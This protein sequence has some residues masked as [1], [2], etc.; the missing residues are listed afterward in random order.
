MIDGEHF[1]ALGVLE[2]PILGA[3][4]PFTWLLWV[5]L[6]RA[7]FAIFAR[8]FD[9]PVRSHAEPLFG[10]VSN[11]V[12]FYPDT[13]GIKARLHLRD[14]LLRP[15]IELEPTSHPLA[16][17]QREGYSMKEAERLMGLLLH[18]HATAPDQRA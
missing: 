9:D 14:D 2:T 17:A 8:T 11:Q 13:L 16:V 1:F 3:P 4:E 18:H 15:W 5:S 7:S 10:W 12:P 6:S